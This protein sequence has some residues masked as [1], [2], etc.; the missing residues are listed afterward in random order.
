MDRAEDK[1]DYG[2]NGMSLFIS[3]AIVTEPTMALDGVVWV[4]VRV[5]GPHTHSVLLPSQPSLR[6]RGEYKTCTTLYIPIVM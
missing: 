3:G 6:A 2:T 5:P 1:E 4:W